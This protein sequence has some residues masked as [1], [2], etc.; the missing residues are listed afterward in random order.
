MDLPIGKQ[1]KEFWRGHVAASEKFSGSIA[2]Y[3]RKNGLV[4]SRFIYHRKTLT[5][6]SKFSEVRT[7]A[8]TLPQTTIV[9]NSTY[10]QRLPDPKWLSAFVREL[11]R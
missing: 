9:D 6:K 10:P 3:C 2:E 11:S 1:G 4:L 7:V 5:I 8:N